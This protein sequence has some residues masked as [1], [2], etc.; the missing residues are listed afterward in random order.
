M[1]TGESI[2]SLPRIG[3]ELSRVGLFIGM[4][5]GVVPARM[6]GEQCSL[7]ETMFSRTL[8]YI[9]VVGVRAIA[10]D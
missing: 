1:I 7:P 9:A 2:V 3:I 4:G 10:F 8:L 6:A 5:Q